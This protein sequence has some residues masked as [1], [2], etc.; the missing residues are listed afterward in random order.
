MKVKSSKTTRAATRGTGIESVQNCSG[1]S[2]DQ[3]LASKVMPIS[4]N[5]LYD[6]LRRGEI[7]SFRLG[8]R[9]IIPTAPLLRKLGIEAV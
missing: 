1:I 7:E 6:A 8:K 2:P 4:R 5:G 3:L 9:I